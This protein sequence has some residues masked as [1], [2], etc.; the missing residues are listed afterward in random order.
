MNCRLSVPGGLPSL[1]VE[2]ADFIPANPTG[3][4]LSRSL[5]RLL[6]QNAK[7]DSGEISLKGSIFRSVHDRLQH[8]HKNITR[9]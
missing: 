8:F 1:G 2:T 6:R 7:T 9:Q 4:R 3:E 5:Q